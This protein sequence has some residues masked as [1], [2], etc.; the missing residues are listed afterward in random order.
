MVE[1]ITC[2]DCHMPIVLTKFGR[3]PRHGWESYARNKMY[4]GFVLTSNYSMVET[5][6][7]CTGSGKLIIGKG[8]K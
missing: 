7:A 1:F 6:P 3:I 2:P 8:S 5:K 4:N